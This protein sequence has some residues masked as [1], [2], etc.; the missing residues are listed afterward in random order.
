V[1]AEVGEEEEEEEDG[2]GSGESEPPVTFESALEGIHTVR[3]Y[4][5]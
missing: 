4:L 1:S 5:M 2:G 3:K